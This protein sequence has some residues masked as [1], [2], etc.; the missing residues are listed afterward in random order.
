MDAEACLVQDYGRFKP[1]MPG[2]QWR[3]ETF[4]V[5]QLWLNEQTYGGTSQ[6]KEPTWAAFSYEAGTLSW[7]VDFMNWDDLVTTAMLRN[8]ESIRKLY[9]WWDV[10]AESRLDP[11]G[12]CL[13]T[14]QR[15]GSNDVSKYLL[16]KIDPE[17]EIDADQPDKGPKQYFHV[18]FKAHYDDRCQEDHGKNA[19]PYPEGCMLDPKRITWPMI[20]AKRIAGVYEIVYQQQDVDP[21]TQLVRPAWIDGGID[22]FD[23]VAY[24]GC[25]DNDRA[26]GELPKMVG[27]T[28]R[29]ITIDPS[30]T[31]YW[32]VQ[33]W[34]YQ[35]PPDG[36]QT[37]GI[38]HLVDIRFQR[39]AA[40]EL[41][42]WSHNAQSWVGLL[43]DWWQRAHDQGKPIGWVIMERNAAQRWA[44][45]YEH[46]RRWQQTRGVAVV[47]H[48]TTRNK[49]DPEL[50]VE[51]TIQSVYRHG[52]VRLPSRRTP[53]SRH[54]DQL[55]AE[56]TQ[57][58]DLITTDCVMAQ[59]FGEYHL[60][61]LVSTTM[62]I[63]RIYRDIPSWVREGVA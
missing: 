4:E 53:D 12:L 36:D 62:S 14:M 54:V 16:R 31:Q 43:E 33:D 34:I 18:V 38:R 11:G 35:P 46:F 29:Y 32:S 50:G 52:R 48:E 21:S 2:V 17:F 28:V 63:G 51:A 9:S 24:P 8:E 49:A 23:R 26:P 59:W 55:V 7:R 25:R 3:R 56:V 44:M 6:R 57:W 45:Q 30:P 5:E 39:M 40:P 19:I 13:V 1:I 42:D 58:P 15:L 47:P 22:P 27:A 20:K 37:T 41:L 61:T 10:E 60:P